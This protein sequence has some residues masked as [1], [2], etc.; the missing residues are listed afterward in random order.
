VSVDHILASYAVVAIVLAI[1][2]ILAGKRGGTTLATVSL[3]LMLSAVTF[4]LNPQAGGIKGP[5]AVH[6]IALGVVPIA[7]AT[8]VVYARRNSRSPGAQLLTGAL[9][10]FGLMFGL[11]GTAY[12]LR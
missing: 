10:W 11:F 12:L 3:A 4:F 8:G 6:S 2:L 5:G 1:G 7:L 9:A